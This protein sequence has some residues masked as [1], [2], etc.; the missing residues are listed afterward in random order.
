MLRFRS[1]LVLFGLL[2]VLLLWVERPVALQ[3]AT[4]PS[5]GLMGTVKSADGMP[6]EGVA[7]S[8]RARQET[9][10]TSVWTDQSG[11]YYFPPL[12]DGDYGVWAQ[13]VGFDRPVAGHALTAG[14]TIEQNFTLKPIEDYLYQLSTAE[15]LESLPGGTAADRRMKQVLQNTCSTCH[16]PGFV[17][18]KRFDA[19]G[20]EIII[21][22]MLKIVTDG[23]VPQSGAGDPVGVG[24][25]GVKYDDNVLDARGL[26]AGPHH[27]LMSFY[28]KDIIDYLSRVRGPKPFPIT[29]KPFPRPTGDA[30]QI[31]VVEYDAPAPRG[32]G[33]AK[34][35]TKTGRVTLL[36]LTS[37]SKTTTAP[38]LPIANEY[39][40]GSDWSLGTRAE[41]R[42]GGRHDLVLGSDGNIYYGASN[43]EGDPQGNA[44]F[45]SREFMKLDVK[46]QTISGYGSTPVMSHG[47]G[48]DSKGNLWASTADGVIRLNIE[49]RQL[50]EFKS[51]TPHSRPYDMAI[52]S[53]D[54]VWFSQIA[55]D[56]MGVVDSRTGDVTEVPLTPYTSSDFTREDVEVATRVGSWDWNA[57]LTQTGP[58]R[59]GADRHGDFVWVGLFWT[60]GLAKLDAR[61]KTLAKQYDVPNGHWIHPYKVLVDKNHMVWFSNAN[62]DLLGK[63]NPF[64]ERF[65]MY[66]LPTRGSNVRHLAIDDSTDPLTIWLPYISAQKIA[67]VQFRTKTAP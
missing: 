53:F 27:R 33:V 29:P 35:D 50:S 14:K 24:A 65:T 59:M 28:K 55:I 10:T 12:E 66:P 42:E 6:M 30:T 3:T 17:L 4:S 45:G 7:V 36:T 61:T 32:G 40:S 51:I 56:K 57:A 1:L 60:G 23:D 41:N 46:T 54:N 43:M 34:L 13:A 64:T 26:P 22:Q 21:N 16:Q 25:G 63:F 38:L 52:D 67:R 48:V 18:E 47:K 8:A 11:R 5:A 19:A 49:T 58:R 9:I 15:W 2:G 62:A 39:R 37:D 44:W 31:V 20:W